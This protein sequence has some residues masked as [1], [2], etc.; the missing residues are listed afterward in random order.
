MFGS[1]KLTLIVLLMV[2]Y[3]ANVKAQSNNSVNHELNILR[4]AHVGKKYKFNTVDNSITYLRYLG[5]IQ[6]RKGISYKV[7]TSTWIWGLSHRATNRII[8]YDEDNTYVGNYK[9]TMIDDLPLR[10][11]KGKLIVTNTKDKSTCK[12]DLKDG[13]PKQLYNG[14]AGD[15]YTLDK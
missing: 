9:V 11:E 7:L 2:V 10:L 12:L 5:I 14:C 8:I 15:V 6:T 4:L 1:Q 13:L 3:S